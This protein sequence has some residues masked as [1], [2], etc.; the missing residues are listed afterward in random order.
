MLLFLFVVSWLVKDV[1]SKIQ[2]YGN[3]TAEYGGEA[4]CGCTAPTSK[5]VL[6]VTWQRLFKDESIENLATYSKRFGQQVNEPYKGKVTF[7]EATLNSSSITLRNV[8]WGDEGCYICSFN[9]YPDGSKRD[10]I[11]LTVKGISTVST[12]HVP[13][14][15]EGGEREDVF[16]CS[17]TGKPAPTIDWDSPGAIVVDRTETTV[18]KNSD[19]TFTSSRNLTLRLPADSCSYVECVLNSGSTGHRRERIPF[20]CGPGINTAGNQPSRSHV[21][22]AITFVVVIAVCIVVVAVLLKRKRWSYLRSKD[23]STAGSTPLS[24]DRVEQENIP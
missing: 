20:P 13:G 10:E 11:C 14:R 3:A 18:V 6:Q 23:E 22:V 4:I 7:T 17:A 12:S 24:T 21:A 19:N 1:A 8:A 16:T 2:V 9:A 15:G 5:G